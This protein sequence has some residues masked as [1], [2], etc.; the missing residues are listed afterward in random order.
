MVAT[1]A[2]E[3]R[4]AAFTRSAPEPIV[5]EHALLRYLERKMGVDFD[6][7]RQEILAGGTSK[8]ISFVNSGRV[9]KNGMTLI[10]KNNVV[11]TIE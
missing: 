6:A 3:E 10:I 11:L 7:L 2:L 5:S 4:I 8:A 9:Q 1:T